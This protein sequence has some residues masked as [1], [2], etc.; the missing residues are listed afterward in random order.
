M[1]ALKINS[2]FKVAK[3]SI[4]RPVPQ[5][6][7]ENTKQLIIIIIIDCAHPLKNLV[8]FICCCKLYLYGFLYH[9]PATNLENALFVRY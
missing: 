3:H 7:S 9:L 6:Q 1:N 4:R 2:F 8:L 5:L